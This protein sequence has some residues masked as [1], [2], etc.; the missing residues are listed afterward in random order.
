MREQDVSLEI[1]RCRGM[2]EVEM[3]TPDNAV[4]TPLLRLN[5]SS[6]AT[7]SPASQNDSVCQEFSTAVAFTVIDT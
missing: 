3:G 5:S 1:S 6:I 4:A 2:E 7:I